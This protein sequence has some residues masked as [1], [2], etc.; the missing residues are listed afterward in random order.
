MTVDK[1]PD[2]LEKLIAG[3]VAWNIGLI[4][5]EEGEEKLAGLPGSAKWNKMCF[6]SGVIWHPIVEEAGD[7]ITALLLGFFIAWIKKQLGVDE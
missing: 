7:A 2:G 4:D 3:N 5:G 6:E 1:T